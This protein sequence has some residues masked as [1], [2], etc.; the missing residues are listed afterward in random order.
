MSTWADSC[1]S[2]RGKGCH[3][4]VVGG[5]PA[6]SA[7]ASAAA[8]LGLDVVLVESGGKG[9][10]KACGD[11]FVPAAVA[12]LRSRSLNCEALESAHGA[13]SFD[14]VELRSPRALLWKVLYQEEP[15]WIM[16]RRIVDQRL[17][18]LLPAGV[19]VLY[20]TSV[21]A[22]SVRP[23]G[24]LRVT[25]RGLG[26]RVEELECR[27]V[28]LAAGALDRLSERWGVSGRR[29]V[30]PSIS[31]YVPDPGVTLPVF[32]FLNTC[33]PGYRWA[34]PSPCG[35]INVGICSLDQTQGSRLKSLGRELCD[36][37]GIRGIARWRGGAGGLWTGNGVCWHHDAGLVSCGDAAGLVDPVNGEGLTA[38]L[39]SGLAA[40]DAA[41]RF[42]LHG[43]DVRSLRGYTEWVKAYFTARYAPSPVRS[44]WKQLCG[45]RQQT[46]FATA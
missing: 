20:D 29:S 1:A 21:R 25:A 36:V 11:M 39:A 30:V 42:V 3:V 38:A 19:R 41:A 26:G 17:R 24:I 35:G 8:R 28:V 43:C 7:A 40:G 16:P 10:D 4:V 2:R 15:V 32:E 18:E 22:V 5:G 13:R 14:T 34:F 45:I 31:A 46:Q 27:A 23:G 44:A 12:M 9:R 37:Y 33:R 6:G